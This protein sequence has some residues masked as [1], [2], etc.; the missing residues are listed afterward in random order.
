MKRWFLFVCAL[1]VGVALMPLDADAARGRMGSGKSM[2]V[3][4]QAQPP[5]KAT[6]PTQQQQ[7][8][9]AG[10][11]QTPAQAAPQR[12]RWLGPL[13]GLAAGLGLGWLFANGGFGP[14]VGALLMAL[15][16]AFVV[17]AVL[18]YISSRNR[19]EERPMQYAGMGSETVAAPPPSQQLPLG[20]AS[21]EP[22]SRSQFAPNIPAGFDVEGFLKQAKRNF[23]ALQEANDRGDLN[24]LREVTT[25]EMFNSLKDEVAARAGSKQQ[26][27]VVNL[28]ASLLEL[29]TEGNQHWASVRFT[30]TIREDA[31]ELPQPFEEIW[32]LQKPVDDSAGWTLAGIQQVR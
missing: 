24:A 28:N 6:P 1:F 26:T 4:R 15:L 14:M 21:S 18:R 11:A 32:H 30:G 17:M 9:Q 27:D 7:A 29:V 2:G 5:Q 23:L 16:A 8:Q 20:S 22:A 3:Q 10:Q 12:S 31:S 25:E 13:A 19:R